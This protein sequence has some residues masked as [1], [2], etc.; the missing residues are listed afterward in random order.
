MS[1]SD[2]GVFPCCPMTLSAGVGG[3]WWEG[4]GGV[5]ESQNTQKIKAADRKSLLNL[6]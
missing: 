5:S 6:H 3:G 4:G 1:A 2:E